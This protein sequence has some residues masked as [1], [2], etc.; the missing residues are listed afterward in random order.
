MPPSFCGA[1]FESLP[2]GPVLLKLEPEAPDDTMTA[3]VLVQEPVSLR[4]I[5]RGAFGQPAPVVTFVTI[6]Q[7]Q[8]RLR[9]QALIDGVSESSS[10]PPCPHQH[11]Q[12]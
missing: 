10:C 7:G 11:L 12:G 9:V 5:N 1:A 8:D 6:Q 3:A 4:P 2:V